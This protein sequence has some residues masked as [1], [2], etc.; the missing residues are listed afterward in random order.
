MFLKN[1]ILASASHFPTNRVSSADLD[2]KYG[3]ESGSFE[4]KSGVKY[5]YFASPED[6]SAKMGAKCAQLALDRAGLKATDIDLILGACGTPEQAIPCTAS[7]IQKEMGLEDS[8]IAC[9]D[10][11]ATC[12]SFINAYNTAA[13][14]IQAGQAKRVLIVSSEIASV[15]INF[16]NIEAASLFG[17]GAVAV[18]VEGCQDKDDSPGILGFHMET[19][20]Q[21]AEACEIQGGGS[22]IHPR[23]LGWDIQKDDPRFLFSMDGP[24]VF[25]MAAQKIP[26]FIST[27]LTKAQTPFDDIKLV[28]PHQ[29][30]SAALSIMRRRLNISEDRF[31][32]FN[33]NYGNMIAASLP[34]GLHLAIQEK[35]VQKGDKVL[36]VGTSAGLSIGGLVL[37]I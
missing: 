7:L 32:Q 28:I 35:R 12:L 19:Y 11:N 18:I 33:E 37:Q 34:L 5:R 4:S 23:R 22:K 15:G 2:A 8:G 13:L 3:A 20:S 21:H 1:R 17:D 26:A 6:T 10:V 16:D 31:F 14:M 9:F 27:L 29:A 24:R 25:K 36:L 30:S